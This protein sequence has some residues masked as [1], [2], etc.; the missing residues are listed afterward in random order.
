MIRGRRDAVKKAEDDLR[1]LEQRRQGV[2]ANL[3]RAEAELDV[4]VARR[5]EVARAGGLV[6]IG[7]LDQE[8]ADGLRA[9]V[10]GAI[11]AASRKVNG[12]RA[13]A[14]ELDSRLAEARIA[15]EAAR[16]GKATRDYMAELEK[17]NEAARRL[18]AA[19]AAAAASELASARATAEQAWERVQA[20][21]G[22][23]VEGELEDEPSWRPSAWRD[24]VGI[25]EKGP[26]QP[27]ARTEV[28]IEKLRRQQAQT[29]GA[30]VQDAVASFFSTAP[31][32]RGEDDLRWAK[33]QALPERLQPQAER[34]IEARKKEF[35]A[36]RA[37]ARATR[38]PIMNE[39]S[40]R[41]ER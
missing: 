23:D 20:L 29:D 30:L 24:L 33:V 40:R 11:D 36:R 35:A 37:A 9:E 22:A 27:R 7:E 16:H 34:A 14:V 19:L 18:E 38:E 31:P 26:R 13:G 5:A 3:E 17:R 1:A 41:W 2:A 25:V 21:G 12:L 32:I 39:G 4:V 8:K 6:A 10:E 15:V 28:E